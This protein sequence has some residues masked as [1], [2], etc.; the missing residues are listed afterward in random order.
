MRAAVL[1]RY[2]APLQLVERAV[3]RPGP[4]E[5]L[6]RVSACGVCGSDLFLQKGGFGGPLPIVPGHE[7]SGVVALLGEGLA[8][9]AVG[10]PV[11]I[12]YL[13]FCGQCEWCRA[14]R[15]NICRSVKR[16]GVDLDGAF[17]EFIVV[18]ASNVLVVP[19]HVPGAVLAVLTDAMSTPYH[20]LTSIAR[21]AAGETI[22]VFGVGG[23]GSCAIQIGKALGGNVIAVSRSPEKLALARRLGA[24]A[25]L[26]AGDDIAERVRAAAGGTGPAV[27]LQCV[28]DARVD[29]QAIAAARTGARVV[30]LGASQDVFRT[31]AVDLI[32]RELTVVGSRGFTPQDIRA[33]LGLYLQG[34]LQTDYLTSRQLPLSR[35]NEALADLSAGRV[36]RSV[37]IPGAEA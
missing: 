6:V 24:D 23:I 18:P 31:R 7:A 21:L 25:A 37:L 14:G 27:V 20:A 26:P 13:R 12:Y 22:A 1:D 28:G 11:A 35:V 15:P 5:V 17:S 19:H 16:I 30:L 32:W 33:V 34:K 2:N 29:E 9:P 10:T 4:G 8:Q 3:P 36:M